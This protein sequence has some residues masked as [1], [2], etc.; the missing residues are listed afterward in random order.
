MT[1]YVKITRLTAGRLIS[2]PFFLL[3]TNFLIICKCDFEKTFYSSNYFV[4]AY[5]D[6]L[7]VYVKYAMDVIMTN[8]WRMILTN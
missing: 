8:P 5:S 6:I 1:I 7:Y 3:N 2:R 4:G